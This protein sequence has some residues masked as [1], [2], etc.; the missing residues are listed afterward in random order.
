MS[1]VL[2]DTS[3]WRHY[4]SGRMSARNTRHMGELLDEVD[5]LRCHPAVIGELV[6]GGLAQREEALLMRLPMSPEVSSADLLRFVRSRKLARKGV[7][8]ID[9]QLL[10]S[11]LL[12]GSELWSFDRVL[13]GVAADIGIAFVASTG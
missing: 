11:S 4:F 6:L 9:C 3:V 2:V 7:G 5:E 10:A 12:D 13:D 1:G 8:W